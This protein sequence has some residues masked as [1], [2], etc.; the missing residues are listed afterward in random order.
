MGSNDDVRRWIPELP[1]YGTPITVSMLI[2]HTSGL[3]D[4]LSLFEL[5]GLDRFDGLDPRVV[6]AMIVRQQGIAFTPGTSY[7]YSNTGY[8]LLAEIVK[9]SSGIAF[10]EFVRS[11]ILAPL[12][13]RDSF[14]RNG[15]NPRAAKVA[16]GYVLENGSLCR[17]GH[18]SG[19]RRIGGPHDFGARPAEVRPG[20][21][22]RPSHL[23]RA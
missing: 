23:D 18:L 5:G 1:D 3:G 4:Y 22:Y 19:I 13:M 6:F 14:V 8:F 10:P 11:R 2:H 17:E 7:Q 16:H 15:A 12:A 9:R 21:S 20:L